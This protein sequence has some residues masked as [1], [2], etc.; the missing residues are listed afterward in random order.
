MEAGL[1]KGDMW[2]AMAQLGS[3]QAQYGWLGG[4]LLP[5]SHL[6]L[7]VSWASPWLSPHHPGSGPCTRLATLPR[8]AGVFQGTG[9]RLAKGKGRRC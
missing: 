9:N 2:F 8:V 1:E 4:Q 5:G 7:P 3:F 6:L